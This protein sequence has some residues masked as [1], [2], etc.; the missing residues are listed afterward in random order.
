M[1]AFGLAI[2][3]LLVVGYFV[4]NVYFLL[5]PIVFL[6]VWNPLVALGLGYHFYNALTGKAPATTI[7]ESSE[8]TTSNPK[9]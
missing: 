7:V 1:L 5:V 9:T 2:L 3:S 8:S 6:V 4:T